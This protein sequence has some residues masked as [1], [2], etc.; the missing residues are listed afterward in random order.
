VIWAN[1]SGRFTLVGGKGGRLQFSRA[2][3]SYSV[4]WEMLVGDVHLAL[5]ASSLSS[6]SSSSAAL[7]DGDFRIAMQEFVNESRL[8]AEIWWGAGKYEVLEPV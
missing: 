2:S 3:Q 1:P 5:Y 7:S 6:R 8:R 4:D